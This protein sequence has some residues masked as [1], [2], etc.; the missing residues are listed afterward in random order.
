MKND[1]KNL[2]RQILGEL[3]ESLSS[4]DADSFDRLTGAVLRTARRGGK[5]YGAAA[6]R[7]LFV[8]QGLVMRLNQMGIRA[9]CASD[10]YVEPISADDLVIALTS[11]GT[12][13]TVVDFGLR[14]K[15][16]TG[17]GLWMIGCNPDSPLAA[18][19]DGMVLFRPSGSTR[20]L[21]QHDQLPPIASAQPMNC[22][23]EQTALLLFDALIMNLM[24]EQGITG[25]DM[26]ARHF[27]LE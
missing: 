11:S 14:A 22:L 17:S 27:N 21:R 8:M 3:N 19:A 4:I 6:G 23:N 16:K 24:N 12:T 1:L 25:S 26:N 20:M 10:T 15:E 5:V 13:H 2:N 18:K 7:M 9:N